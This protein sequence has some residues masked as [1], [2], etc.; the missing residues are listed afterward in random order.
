[1]LVR[2]SE[3]LV[4]E[5]LERIAELLRKPDAPISNEHARKAIRALRD[6]LQRLCDCLE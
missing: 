6:E 5:R 4:A 3:L 2:E 1:M